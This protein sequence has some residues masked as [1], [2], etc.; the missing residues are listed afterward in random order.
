M[1]NKTAPTTNLPKVRTFANDLNTARQN[2]SAPA[3]IVG[4][5]VSEP[6]KEVKTAP[7]KENLNEDGIKPLTPIPSFTLKKELESLADNKPKS[8]FADN[9]SADFVVDVDNA[10]AESATVIT[11]TK[12][13][14][15]KLLPAIAA[16]IKSWF[17]TKQTERIK[18]KAPKYTVADSKTRKN[19]IQKATSKSGRLATADFTSIQERIKQR[20]KALEDSLKKNTE[21][22]PETFW[23]A[24]TEPGF[25]LLESPEAP[26][27]KNVQ[28]VEKKTFK[29][30]SPKPITTES[31]SLTAAPDKQGIIEVPT[32]VTPPAV[33]DSIKTS[34]EPEPESPVIVPKPATI[35]SLEEN[36]ET[37]AQPEQQNA[38]DEII[39]EETG[40]STD[41]NEEEVEKVDLKTKL[42]RLDTNLASILVVV[43]L[44]AT[45]IA[46]L[47]VY[48]SIKEQA[49]L[50]QQTAETPSLL[51]NSKPVV[52]LPT[53]QNQLK[54]TLQSNRNSGQ[55]TEIVL[56]DNNNAVVSPRN[57][58]IS[59]GLTGLAITDQARSLHFGLTQNQEY[60]IG[61]KVSDSRSAL[62]AMLQ[63]ERSLL[64]ETALYF[65]NIA[66]TD[67]RFFDGSLAGVDVRVFRSSSGSELLIYGIKNNVLI[68]TKDSRSFSEL[69]NQIK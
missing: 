17:K 65:N 69:L 3:T 34:P 61:V 58:F 52:G 18:N 12:K 63:W 47:F 51:T 4:A 36:A 31:V 1:D 14:R 44:V 11:D 56:V 40:S 62:G 30:I 42:L 28:V 59:L 9:K 48:F 50:L 22:E 20:R 7:K 46:G 10:D 27:I 49:P 54:E 35:T 6:K 38:T 29:N 55:V 64:N 2:S 57:I 26:V 8:V 33:E 23:S 25:L 41:F 45:T 67:G 5:P 32:P 53:S 43:I 21:D 15:F 39:H 19:V 60:Y 16:S 24:K 13:D 66:E 37:A 68:I